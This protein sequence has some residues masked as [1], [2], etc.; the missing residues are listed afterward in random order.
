MGPPP[1]VHRLRTVREHL[2]VCLRLTLEKGGF[3]DDDI[4][5]QKPQYLQV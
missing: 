3:L 1:I 5:W 2:C 4:E